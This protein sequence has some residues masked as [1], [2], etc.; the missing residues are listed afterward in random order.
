ML[1]LDH[2]ALACT[3]LAAS[4][5]LLSQ[6]IGAPLQT[7]GQ[8]PRYG[9]HNVLLGMGD[10]YLELIA[11]DPDAAQT[12]RPTW[13]G[14]DHFTG[15]MRPANWICRT[16]DLGAERAKMPVDPGPA[17]PLTRGDLVWDITVPDDGSLPLDGGVP[18][19]IQ[20]AAGTRHPVDRLPDSTCRLQHWTVYHPQAQMLQNTLPLVDHRVQFVAGPARFAM[21]LQ[22]PR[23][24]VT[25]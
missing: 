14:L 12:G 15:P 5:D 25:L 22:T 6:M 7:G 10:I 24:I 19:L 8:H 23:G 18:T 2:I 3:D 11:R 20:W 17:V 21:T 13:F 1:T 4:A 9:T 16:D